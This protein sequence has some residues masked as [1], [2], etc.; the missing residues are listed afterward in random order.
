MHTY[1]KKLTTFV[2]L[3]S[4]FDGFKDLYA[5]ELHLGNETKEFWLF[6]FNELIDRNRAGG[7]FLINFLKEV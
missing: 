6:L 4:D 3:R 2:I 7:F 5:I 1:L